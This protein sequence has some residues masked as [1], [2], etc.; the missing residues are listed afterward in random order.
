MPA[1][2]TCSECGA[3]LAGHG[4]LAVTCSNKCRQT[5]ARRQRRDNKKARELQASTNATAAE[6][7]QMVRNE[8]QGAV[9]TVLNQELAPI[10]REAIDDEILAAIDRL[11]NLTPQAVAVLAADLE[12]TVT[13][14]D[15]K[16][17][18][19]V[20]EMPD[21][22]RRS[23]AAQL[24]MKYTVGH[25][26][27]APAPAGVSG[28]VV[29]NYLPR[30]EDDGANESL[31]ADAEEMRRCDVCGVDKP[32]RDFV[33]PG[34]VRCTACHNELRQKALEKFAADGSLPS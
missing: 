14:T 29:N 26:A 23:R 32:E 1:P 17:P 20:I 2:R 5:R 28:L 7:R 6:V 3:S 25:P 11:V 31:V 8:A 27:L 4:P 19:G 18:D 33:V 30:P 16:D 24:V 21:A 12:S 13:Y 9:A 22:T 10:V 34:S 15:P